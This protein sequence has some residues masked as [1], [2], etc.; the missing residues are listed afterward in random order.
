MRIVIAG[1]GTQGYKRKNVAGSE[2]IATVDPTNQ[3][4]DYRNLS[5]VP[6]AAYDAVL[7]CVPD[8]EKFNLIHKC[9]ENKKH[10]LVEKPLWS[11]SES[12]LLELERFAHEANI[13]IYTAYNHRF[14]PSFRK[15]KK[16]IESGKLGKLYSC[17]IFYGNGT[18]RLVRESA[19]RD[20]GS[21]VL[22]DLGS[23]LLDM[24]SYWFGDIKG[25]F[26]I[27]SVN[28][29]ENRSADHAVLLI[30][31]NSPRIELE[32]TLL[33]WKNHFSC[34]L[35]GEHGSAHIKSLSKWDSSDFSIHWR[36]LPSG[37]PAEETIMFP[38]GDP[39]WQLEYD[40]FKS[41]C[42]R[43]HP[44]ELSHDLWIYRNLT[45]IEKTALL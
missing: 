30:Q 24:T 4:A 41:L 8:E 39:T 35:F 6:I 9:I 23:H 27:L 14:E 13:L 21:G 26:K 37:K 17:R 7:A 42:L 10:V 33:S 31:E 43:E 32:M 38:Q 34:D 15:L 18:A 36:I 1:L 40:H 2:C 19:W 45:Q 28:A 20:K 3:E 29:F 12:Q 11:E 25:K 44:T 16:L 5:E 22:F